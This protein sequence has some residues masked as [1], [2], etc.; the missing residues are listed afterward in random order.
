[1]KSAKSGDLAPPKTQP[2]H[3]DPNTLGAIR[4]QVMDLIERATG[5]RQAI[6]AHTL[7]VDFFD[8]DHNAAIVLNQIL[9]WTSR[10]N[11]PDGWFHKTYNQW[12]DELRFSTY[13][14][15]RVIRGDDRVLKEKRTLWSIGL[16]TQVRMAPNGRNA[17]HYR[18]NIPAF[19][20]A[21]TEWLVET[22]GL[23][24]GKHSQPRVPRTRT[25]PEKRLNLFERHKRDFGVAT[26]KHR[27]TVWKYQHQLGR[28]R[29]QQIVANCAGR[30]RDW[31][32]V[33]RE[34]ED[35]ILEILTRPDTDPVQV[36]PQPHRFDN[37]RENTLPIT[38]RITAALQ[39]EWRHVTNVLRLHMRSD[40]DALLNGHQLVDRT[41]DGE[42]TLTVAVPTPHA[43][44]TLMG[45]WNRFVRRYV[46]DALGR[47]VHLRFVPRE[48]WARQHE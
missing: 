19:M 46:S 47:E 33:C 9:Y 22:H 44:E 40:Y 38:Q 15:M 23:V 10:T 13:Q 16:E 25:Q 20:T 26:K 43:A 24:L 39:D 45:R 41:A 3:P 14:M 8:R 48:Q 18:L 32:G 30:V 7:I 27:R 1:M 21:F 5:Q 6:I 35:A 28:S 4:D 11:D 2:P 36:Q 42:E 29:T 17:V 31:N 37:R 12:R 34:L